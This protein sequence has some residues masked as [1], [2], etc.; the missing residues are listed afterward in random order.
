M[1]YTINKLAKMSGVSTR[2][3]RYY[4][5]IELLKPVRKSSNGYRIYGKEEVN[6]LQQILFY[7]ELDV[8]LDEIKVILTSHDFNLQASLQSHLE[9][10]TQKRNRI[11]LLIENVTKT[12]QTI[13]GEIIMTDNEKFEGFKQN[14][15]NENE[16]KY[17]K[18]IREKYGDDAVNASNAKVKGMTKEQH[19][20][21]VSLQLEFEETLKSAFET[22]DPASDLAQKA[23][24]LHKQW[25]CYFYDGYCKEYHKG[26]GEMYV[27]DE[28]FRVHYDKLAPNCT[29]FL[30]DAIN[31]YCAQ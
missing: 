10:L 7:R 13:K 16:A 28:R 15:I 2:T 18:E 25:L 6:R 22:K 8:S 29:E 17:G 23:C 30:R 4:D 19:E 27:A 1:E 11:D 20:E 9:T 3:L 24:E 5:Q 14:L 31:I 12:I 21:V 26:L